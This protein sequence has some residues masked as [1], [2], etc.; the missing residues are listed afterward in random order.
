MKTRAHQFLWLALILVFPK[1]A[2]SQAADCGSVQTLRLVSDAFGNTIQERLA[3]H[4]NPKDIS[5]EIVRI[6]G[7]RVTEIRTAQAD[8][9]TAKSLCEANIE[10][11]LPRDAA[12][13]ANDPVT[14]ARLATVRGS[15]TMR[16]GAA[17]IT[18][19]I[20]YVAQLT[21]DKKKITVQVSG[22]QLLAAL[23]VDILSEDAVVSMGPKKGGTGSSP[24][25]G[26]FSPSFDCKYA[27]GVA[28]RLICGNRELADADTRLMALYRNAV[29]NPKEKDRISGDQASWRNTAY[30]CTTV[31]C[32]L[33]AHQE[34]IAELQ[35]LA[36]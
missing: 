27:S 10:V 6:V 15:Q 11:R 32:L 20:R 25:S 16:I 22:H 24:E 19:P 21:D 29:A 18:Q 34:R 14:R 35:K 33:K 4:P 3:A 17:G 7:L 12:E 2:L 8:R 26:T 5:D 9:T 30:S 1:L 31:P 28:E 36:Q 13:K 23:L